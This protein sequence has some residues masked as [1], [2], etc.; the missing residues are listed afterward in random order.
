MIEVEIRS[1]N[2]KGSESVGRAQGQAADA[3]STGVTRL[4]NDS[5]LSLLH[6]YTYD[7]IEKQ[8]V[9]CYKSSS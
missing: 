7:R 1:K 4:E 2:S 9:D 6:F 8:V 3:R 5:E